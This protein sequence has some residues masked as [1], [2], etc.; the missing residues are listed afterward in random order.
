[1]DNAPRSR[2]DWGEGMIKAGDK[3]WLYSS[4]GKQ[5]VT[6]LE[7]GLS[8]QTPFTPEATAEMVMVEYPNGGRVFAHERQLDRI[9]VTE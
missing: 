9:E 7:V 3:M 6:V 5:V 2:E 8:V 1:M 4:V